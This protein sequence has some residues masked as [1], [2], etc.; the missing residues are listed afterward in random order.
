MVTDTELTY[1]IDVADHHYYVSATAPSKNMS[2]INIQSGEDVKLAAAM[3]WPGANGVIRF[4]K[5]GAVVIQYS[6]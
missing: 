2:H 6:S 5:V 3:D 4:M 1:S